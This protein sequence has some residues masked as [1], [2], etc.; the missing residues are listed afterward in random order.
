[1]N[2][3]LYSTFNTLFLIVALSLFSCSKRESASISWVIS[4]GV[5]NNYDFR[6]IG[7]Q[8]GDNFPDLELWCISGNTVALSE[9]TAGEKGAV[10]ITGSYTCDKTRMNLQSIDS[11]SKIYQ[12]SINF[13]I[14]NTVEAHP[15]NIQSPYSPE[16]EPWLAQDNLEVGIEAHQPN[17]MKER[18]DLAERWKA[19]QRIKTPILLDGP[20]NEFWSQA[21]QA[22]NMTIVISTE[23]KILHKEAWFDAGILGDFL[24]AP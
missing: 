24:A 20:E 4:Q 13:F 1:M 22:P 7:L 9:I 21:G 15:N 14:V 5:M 6:S 10:L 16:P 8:V 3:K 23:G 2:A 17:T 12:D 18:M 19:E 11:L